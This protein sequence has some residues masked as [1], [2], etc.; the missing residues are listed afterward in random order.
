[1]TISK[2]VKFMAALGCMAVLGLMPAAVL[3]ENTVKGKLTVDGKTVE[4][5]N[6]VA[7]SQPGFFDKKKRD[8]VVLMC[9]APV[10]LETAKDT[11]GIHDQVKAGKLHCVRHT[12]N[13]EKQV[14]NF[15]VSHNRFKMPVGGG[16][17]YEIFEAKTFTG[18]SVA[19]RSFTKSPQ[20]AP[21]DDVTYSYDITFSTD[22]AA[23]QSR[24]VGTKLP[25]G[26]GDL[27][28]AYL[29]HNKM[30]K[31][32]DIKEMRKM[33]PPDVSKETSDEELKALKEL[34]V[35]MMPKNPKFTEGYVNGD[36]GVLFISDKEKTYGVIDMKKEKGEWTVEKESWSDNPP[37]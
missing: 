15:E 11:F 32:M 37:E 35:A 20:K 2:A 36:K 27:W 7:Y 10:D 26:G 18:S 12:I 25:A 22:I 21:F 13:S 6:V 23:P 8:V 31:N 17:S 4:I 24:K 16:S 30:V 33:M 34:A 14:I 19:G 9:D 1:M 29:A 3:A 28:K 5:N